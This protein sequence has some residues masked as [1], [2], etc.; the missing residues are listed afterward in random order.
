MLPAVDGP[1]QKSGC[2]PDRDTLQSFTVA[3][4]VLTRKRSV[5]EAASTATPSSRACQY[6]PHEGPIPSWNR[7]CFLRDMLRYY[8]SHKTF[9]FAKEYASPQSLRY[10]WHDDYRRICNPL[11]HYRGCLHDNVSSTVRM[12]CMIKRKQ[13][14]VSKPRGKPS[15]VCSANTAL[16][17][18]YS[19]YETKYN[20]T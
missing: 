11:H 4:R 7:R 5:L 17:V 18:L 14:L 15:A 12:R 20:M 2:I 9:F 3:R 13:R 10:P 1:I 19:T 6:V 16:L 8:S